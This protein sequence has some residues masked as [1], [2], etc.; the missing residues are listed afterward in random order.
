M[1]GFLEI[2]QEMYVLQSSDLW[3]RKSS[4]YVPL[5]ENPFNYDDTDLGANARDI[6][7]VIAAEH[8]S[9]SG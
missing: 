3:S 5:S 1:L 4:D 2:G 8:A 7:V 6:A 9:R